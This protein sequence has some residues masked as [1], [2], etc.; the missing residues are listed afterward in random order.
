M[1]TLKITAFLLVLLLVLNFSGCTNNPE[2]GSGSAIDENL[3]STETAK[4]SREYMTLLYS[5]SDTF[6]PYTLKTNVN[7]TISLQI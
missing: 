2:N 3:Q 6:N 7:R 5:A 1:K 4:S